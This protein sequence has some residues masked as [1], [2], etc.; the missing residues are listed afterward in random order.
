MV[1]FSF[2]LVGV[3]FIFTPWRAAINTQIK[4]RLLCLDGR[5]TQNRFIISQEI[6]FKSKLGLGVAITFIL[7]LIAAA[8]SSA[9]SALTSLTTSYCI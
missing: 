8:Y 2:V 9:D 1:V 4:W 6:A 3:T 5:P 7:G